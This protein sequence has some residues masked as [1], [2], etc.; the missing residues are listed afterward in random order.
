MSRRGG[1]SRCQSTGTV[2][3]PQCHGAGE[4]VKVIVKGVKKGFF[5][6]EVP[7]VTKTEKCGYCNHGW[8]ICNSC[9]GV[10]SFIDFRRR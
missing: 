2:Q 10:N 4:I 6:R 8:V 1:C 3:C 9:G 5:R 7:E